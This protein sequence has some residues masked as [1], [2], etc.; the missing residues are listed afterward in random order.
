MAATSFPFFACLPWEIR[1]TIWTFAVG[2]RDRRGAHHFTVVCANDPAESQ[3]WKPHYA[4]T[5]GHRRGNINNKQKNGSH[6]APFALAAPRLG[7]PPPGE[8]QVQPSWLANNPSIY[9]Q[10]SGLWTACRESREVMKW[11]YSKPRYLTEKSRAM[12]NDTITIESHPSTITTTLTPDSS[13]RSQHHLRFTVF[14]HSDLFI[15]Q[16]VSYKTLNIERIV[17]EIF[18]LSP[19]SSSSSLFSLPHRTPL[20]QSP[21]ESLT[22]TTTRYNS[23]TNNVSRNI[24]RHLALE[25]NP[26]WDTPPSYDWFGEWMERH[27]LGTIPLDLHYIICSIFLVEPLVPPKIKFR[28]LSR[29]SVFW[30]G[31]TIWFI[32]RRI[33]VDDL[34]EDED[35][36]GEEKSGRVVFYDGRDKYVSINVEEIEDGEDGD[37]GGSPKGMMEHCGLRPARIG[38][39]GVARI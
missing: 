39:L 29:D 31:L 19:P 33:V 37:G 2:P 38:L 3:A 9:L 16:P 15:L 5:D 10:D 4:L 34:N 27:C 20:S 12:R 26:E 22:T 23:N 30:R 25:Y 35:E 11:I 1:N 24:I 13:Q 21:I 8:N 6:P 14:P 36:D 28:N 18:P 7:K 17:K 32:D